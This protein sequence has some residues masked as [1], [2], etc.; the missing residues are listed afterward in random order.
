MKLLHLLLCIG[1]VL[2]AAGRLYGIYSGY[3]AGTRT[4]VELVRKYVVEE[5]ENGSG[6][7]TGMTA[8]PEAGASGVPISVD[9]EA[10][11]KECEDVAAWIYCEDTPVNYPIVQGEDNDYYLKRMLNGQY[12]DSGTLFMDYRN[13]GDFT[14]WNTLIY[15]HN[16]H[17]GA[18]FAVLPEYMEQEFYDA[19]SVWYLLTEDKTYRIQLV[20]G[21]VTSTDSVIYTIPKNPEERNVLYEKAS[22]SSS[23]LSGTRL[24]EDDRLITL[25]TCVYDYDDARYVLVGVLRETDASEAG[26]GKE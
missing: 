16:M 24:Q 2:F 22:R 7:E 19:H 12:N 15:G 11:G 21:F 18:M 25:S 3:E 26:A 1:L 20:G 9:F 14:D 13:S 5:Q 6:P 8:Q 17:N 4:Y 10:L 23:F